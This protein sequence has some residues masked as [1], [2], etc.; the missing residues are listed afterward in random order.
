MDLADIATACDLTHAQVEREIENLKL[1]VVIENGK[2]DS[3]TVTGDYV[4]KIQGFS[5]N[6]GYEIELE[7]DY[8]NVALS[9]P[10]DASSY[11][12]LTYDELMNG[13]N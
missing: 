10:A 2:Y 13:L 6:V 5:F 12:T 8:E 7:F 1:V 4:I 11:Q 3:Y 9:K